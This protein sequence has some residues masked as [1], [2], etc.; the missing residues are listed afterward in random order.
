MTSRRTLIALAVLSLLA[1]IPAA[2]AQVPDGK[3]E[4]AAN[5]AL[6]YWQAFS[7]IPTLD[8]DQEKVLAEWSTVA[9]DDPTIAGASEDEL[10]PT[11]MFSSSR[12][13]VREVVVGGK[14]IVS[15]GQHLIQE[16]V[17]ERF[18]GLQKRLWG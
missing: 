1:G 3:S 10:L 18:K 16:E 17:I 5:A 15:E 11:I 4:L 14:P 13:A 12:V 8:K 7:Q 6:Q 9:L 2:T